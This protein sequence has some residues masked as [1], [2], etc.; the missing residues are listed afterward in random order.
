MATPGS[1]NFIAWKVNH[2]APNGNCTIRLGTGPDESDFR[3]LHPLD[4]SANKN[5]SF[6]CGREETGL[7]GK[8]VKFPKNLTCDTCTL[9]I[10]WTVGDKGSAQQHYCADVQVIDKEAEECSGKCEN[11]GI[12]MNGECRCRKGTSGN[13]CQYKE[14]DGPTF[15]LVF[16]YFIMFLVSVVLILGLFY[17]AFYLI[18]KIVSK[19]LY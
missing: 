15:G 11:G 17:G 2:P 3:V 1:R 10:E 12:C 5:G 9:Q 8:E 4:K 16:F 18:K 13:Y 6:P 14:T 7:E 19:S